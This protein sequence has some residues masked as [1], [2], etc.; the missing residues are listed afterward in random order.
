MREFSSYSDLRMTI[1]ALNAINASPAMARMF[2]SLLA[3][4]SFLTVTACAT[5]TPQTQFL[6]GN[7]A[8]TAN[9]AEGCNPD[10]LQYTTQAESTYGESR[11]AVVQTPS[12]ASNSPYEYQPYQGEHT[13]P[14]DDEAMFNHDLSGL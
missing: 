10:C 13:K 9:A 2:R 12:L 4:T 7:W 8:L 6:P 3:C 11:S 14:A 1:S 5:N